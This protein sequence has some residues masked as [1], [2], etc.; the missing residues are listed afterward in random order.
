M[1]LIEDCIKWGTS[2]KRM[3]KKEVTVLPKFL[4]MVGNQYQ[5]SV[6][7]YQ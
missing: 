5:A 1:R 3:E 2:R 6:K 4:R 7:T